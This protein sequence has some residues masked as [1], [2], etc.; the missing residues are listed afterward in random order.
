V[1]L[2][3]HFAPASPAVNLLF[4]R[5][6]DPAAIQNDQQQHLSGA[7]LVRSIQQFSVLAALQ[8]VAHPKD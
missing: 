3:E 7:G 4:L 8:A 1:G 5:Y 2:P 6:D